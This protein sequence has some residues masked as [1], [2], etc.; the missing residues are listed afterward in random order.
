[1]AQPTPGYLRGTVF[2]TYADGRW[3]AISN[4]R[5]PISRESPAI[6]PRELLASG[7]GLTRL[8]GRSRQNLRRFFLYPPDDERTSSIEVHN[9]PMKG[10]VIFTSLTTRWLEAK[11]SAIN[12]SHHDVILGGV[13]ISNPYVCGVA[14]SPKPETL[15]PQRRDLLLHIPANIRVPIEQRARQLSQSLPT[16]QAKAS[17]IQAYFQRDFEYS[18]NKEPPRS[19]LDP[20]VNFLVSKHP[21]HCEYFATASVLLLR[22]TGVPARYVTGY[23]TTEHSE[24]EDF[25]LAR[26]RDAHAWVEAY[27]EMTGCWFPVESTP[28]RRYQSMSLAD[29]GNAAADAAAAALAD[30]GSLSDSLLNRLW[31]WITSMR[32]T[33]PLIVIFRLGQIPLFCVVLL[34]L[35]LNFR[36]DYDGETEPNEIKSK[37]MLRRL[38]RKLKKHA[39]IRQPHE[40]LHQ[41][42]S[43]IE[44]DLAGRLA[45]RRRHGDF[46]TQ[47]AQ[48]YRQYASARYGGKMPTPFAYGTSSVNQRVDVP[49][50]RR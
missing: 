14:R 37:Q 13:N 19:R 41:F 29:N 40:T 26:N 32:A 1:M 48:W 39:L 22:G 5:L 4:E 38:D 47:A 6:M 44:Q 49:S 8:E 2:D 43:R 23:V 27:D 16:A 21:A 35:W 15:E 3:S 10:P 34:L 24:E 33:D 18:L 25:W 31:S 36:R 42:A 45:N 50:H 20:I 12:V 9:D 30:D 46:L 11:S 28:G 7:P 17:A